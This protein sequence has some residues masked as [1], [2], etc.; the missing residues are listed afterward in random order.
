MAM[1]AGHRHPIIQLP[2]Q[3]TSGN[4][5]SSHGP[6]H[7][8][9]RLTTARLP[10]VSIITPILTNPQRQTEP[11]SHMRD[12][13]LGTLSFQSSLRHVL[14]RARSLTALTVPEIEHHY[15]LIQIR[16][17]SDSD[18][19]TSTSNTQRQTHFSLTS[20]TPS[21]LPIRSEQPLLLPLSTTN[22]PS[23]I[24]PTTLSYTA[25]VTTSTNIQSSLL[26]DHPTI[27][28]NTDSD[29]IEPLLPRTL[30][31]HDNNQIEPKSSSLPYIT[32]SP[33]Q[34]TNDQV[35]SNSSS[36]VVT[37]PNNN[38]PINTHQ[39]ITH[40]A[41]TTSHSPTILPRRSLR[42]LSNSTSQ[43]PSTIILTKKRFLYTHHNN[44]VHSITSNALTSPNT[45]TDELEFTVILDS[46][47][48]AHMF[49]TIAHFLTYIPYKENHRIRDADGTLVPVLGFGT[50]PVNPSRQ[51]I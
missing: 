11:P 1:D 16:T 26:S 10:Q 13:I 25:S 30:P 2:H 45:G 14:Q 46:R 28:I 9:Y 24:L 31:T 33:R 22:M 29:S 40:H 51:W 20:T 17:S 8:S 15:S 4:Q 41:P 43:R 38:N 48:T 50:L 32:T 39:N 44:T 18:P 49:N 23:A 42:L 34:S 36:V 7:F 47:A 3:T 35:A 6:A 37:L 5:I 12:S 21:L 27:T 19:N